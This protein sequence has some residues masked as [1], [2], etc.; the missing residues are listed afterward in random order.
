MTHGK[1]IEEVDSCCCYY[2][3]GVASTYQQVLVA[4]DSSLSTLGVVNAK[5]S[6][7]LVLRPPSKL[8]VSQLYKGF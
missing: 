2:S 4:Q 6:G 7:G 3:Q 1:C 5:P 8:P